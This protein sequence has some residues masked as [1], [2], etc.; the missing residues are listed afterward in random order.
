MNT[1]GWVKGPGLAVLVDLIAAVQPSHIVSIASGNARKDL[2]PDAFWDTGLLPRL[3][4]IDLPS[5]QNCAPAAENST[6]SPAGSPTAAGAPVVRSSTES[7]SARLHAWVCG[8]LAAQP[9]AELAAA[10]VHRSLFHETWPKSAARLFLCPPLAVRL[11]D[12]AVVSLFEDMASAMV[13]GAL[14]GAIVALASMPAALPGGAMSSHDV[15]ART[16][17]CESCFQ[18]SWASLNLPESRQRVYA[19]LALS[20][21]DCTRSVVQRRQLVQAQMLADPP[22]TSTLALVHSVD[23]KAGES[24]T[25]YVYSSL[26]PKALQDYNV[27]VLGRLPLPAGLLGADGLASPYLQLFCLATEGTASAAIKSRR[28]LARRSQGTTA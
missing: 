28:N 17:L 14:N 8:V 1:A 23:P 13:P 2:P 26:A 6:A 9:G 10:D 21:M 4:R 20:T 27:M 25:A 19:W 11:R 16:V 3:S 22:I 5:L 15:Q 18:T 12:M 24:G 7:R